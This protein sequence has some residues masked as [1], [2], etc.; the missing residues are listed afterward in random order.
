MAKV[1]NSDITKTGPLTFR[2]LYKLNNPGAPEPDDETINEMARQF[3]KSQTTITSPKKHWEETQNR[4][5]SQHRDSGIWA[6]ELNKLGYGDSKFDARL[7]PSDVNLEDLQENR[8][9]SQSTGEKLLNGVL[10]GAITSGTTFVNTLAGMPFGLVEAAVQGDVSKIWD[11]EI[12][13]AMSGI[14]EWSEKA[15]PNYYSKAELESPWY[16]QVFTANFLGDKLIKNF[17]FTIGAGAAGTMVLSRI[18]K[19]LPKVLTK[20]AVAAGRSEKDVA[21]IGRAANSLSTSF[22]SA[23]GEG[24]IEALN[25]TKEWS[26][27]MT[28]DI[29]Q[30]Y[31]EE[32]QAIQERYRQAVADLEEDFLNN[33]PTLVRDAEGNIYNP[34]AEERQKMMQALEQSM[35][36]DMQKAETNKNQRM[37]QVASQRAQTGNAVLAFNLP[38]L[39]MGNLLTLGK[40]YAKGYTAE[41][42]SIG[43]H[44]KFHPDDLANA[45]KTVK[46]TKRRLTWRGLRDVEKDVTKQ[47]FTSDVSLGKN[48]AKT[49]GS[50]AWEGTE[51]MLQGWAA[52]A[53]KD[54]N[55]DYY[56][57]SVDPDYTDK[58]ASM[59]KS[60]GDSFVSTFGNIDN[61]EEFAIGMLSGGIS[62][63]ILGQ[64]REMSRERKAV[65]EAVT[66]LNDAVNTFNN[67]EMIKGINRHQYL[68]D[69]KTSAAIEHRE[70]AYKDA[71][72]AQLASDVVLFGS[73]G[74]L[75]ELKAI[76]DYN[77]DNLSDAELQQ[78]SDDLSQKEVNGPENNYFAKLDLAGKRKYLKDQQ[79]KYHKVIDDYNNEYNELTS[80][81]GGMFSQEQMSELVYERLRTKN[82]SQRADEVKQQLKEQVDQAL[83]QQTSDQDYHNRRL[84]LHQNIISGMK[85]QLTKWSK[86]LAALKKQEAELSAK[87]SST[88]EHARQRKEGI[89]RDLEASY[90]NLFASDIA[91]QQF[92]EENRKSTTHKSRRQQQLEASQKRITQLEKQIEKYLKILNEYEA[93]TG[94]NQRTRLDALGR[95]WQ[96]QRANEK[97]TGNLKGRLKEEQAQIK[98]LQKLLHLDHVNIEG[99]NSALEFISKNLDTIFDVNSKKLY[100]GNVREAAM[101]TIGLGMILSSI[102]TDTVTSNKLMQGVTDIT[103]LLADAMNYN[104]RVSEFLQNPQKLE[105]KNKGIRE[106]VEAK[107]VERQANKVIDDLANTTDFNEFVR[108]LN[109]LDSKVKARVLEKLKEQQNKNALEYE[110]KS[111]K[112]NLVYDFINKANVEPNIKQIA[113]TI[114][115]EASRLL[116]EESLFNIDARV[117]SREA[118]QQ[119]DDETYVKTKTLLAQ[120]FKFQDKETSEPVQND[121]INAS[122]APTTTEKKEAEAKQ[123]SN[124]VNEIFAQ[125]DDDLAATQQLM[126][127]GTMNPNPQGVGNEAPLNL[128]GTTPE[129]DNSAIPPFEK[130][131]NPTPVATVTVPANEPNNLTSDK[132]EVDTT[133][134][135]TSPT[136]P[137]ASSNKNEAVMGMQEYDTK[138]GSANRGNRPIDEKDANGNLTKSAK[139]AAPLYNKLKE[140][141]AFDNVDNGVVKLGSKVYFGLLPA[142]DQQIEAETGTRSTTILMFVNG[143]CVGHLTNFSADSIGKQLGIEGLLREEFKK[144]LAS[145][146]NTNE[147]LIS[148]RYYSVVDELWT[149]SVFYNEQNYEPLTNASLQWVKDRINSSTTSEEDRT[150]LITIFDGQTTFRKGNVTYTYGDAVSTVYMGNPLYNGAPVILVPS[151]AY[152]RNKPNTQQD[153]KAYVPVALRRTLFKDL[154]EN[155]TTYKDILTTIN[156]LFSGELTIPE[157]NRTIGNLKKNLTYEFNT[158][159]GKQQIFISPAMSVRRDDGTYA[160]VEMTPQ[161]FA[162]RHTPYNDAHVTYL[163][164]QRKVGGQLVSSYVMPIALGNE[165][166]SEKL[167]PEFQKQVIDS[168]LNLL[169]GEAGA[170][171]NIDQNRLNDPKYVQQII[172]DELLQ[173]NARELKTVANS[174]HMVKEV[175]EDD[176]TQ[177]PPAVQPTQPTQTDQTNQTEQTTTAEQQAPVAPINPLD[178]L[179]GNN[180]DPTQQADTEGNEDNPQYSRVTEETQTGTID[181]EKEVNNIMRMLPQLDKETAFQI[182]NDFIKINDQ[183]DN[184]QGMFNRG[185]ITLSRLAESGTAYHEAF[186]LVFNMLLT[187][188]E[189]LALMNEY[190]DNYPN[191]SDVDLEEQ[192]ADDFKDYVLLKENN[193]PT[194]FFDRLGK[195]VLEAFNRILNFL[196]LKKHNPTVFQTVASNIWQGKY[197]GRQLSSTDND[198]RYSLPL[199]T[200]I[201]NAGLTRKEYNELKKVVDDINARYRRQKKPNGFAIQFSTRNGETAFFLTYNSGVVWENGEKIVVYHPEISE[202]FVKKYLADNHLG[203]QFKVVETGRGDFKLVAT[204]ELD[205]IGNET[206]RETYQR[207]SAWIRSGYTLTPEENYFMQTYNNKFN[208]EEVCG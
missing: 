47:A 151:G 206:P 128:S 193:R 199:A 33:P 70:K 148:K 16:T 4:L 161:N 21:A 14:E 188:D 176:G 10:K 141:G 88:R 142:L 180:F 64:T 138:A 36:R 139:Y 45:G 25:A 85:N 160:V 103:T 52:N 168:L 39:T 92:Q 121:T 30:Q 67:R 105:E 130:E 77:L 181:V 173:T 28:N 59:W 42:S 94:S 76:V 20:A 114:F 19:L 112:I 205:K 65:N 129:Q 35:I 12:T 113:L 137:P 5:V 150:P 149:G 158:D 195:K 175:R 171:V 83:Q 133:V 6:E 41:M 74:K 115:N 187:E 29:N 2:E 49:A 78:L 124:D 72:F 91:N 117:Y 56:H 100:A 9:L 26:K 123:A 8:A 208:T 61:W 110:S 204:H 3:M 111:K 7:M 104:N 107:R 145:N 152:D 99:Y 184:A 178:A 203:S 17:G 102:S 147:L 143:K 13:N 153:K 46:E 84:D 73:L 192:M 134:K 27:E 58:T 66:K 162:N 135:P 132:V 140:L 86:E 106:R 57:Q 182:V 159:Q 166:L 97:K 89:K 48:I 136:L 190:K 116:P 18:P 34:A 131:E 108:K 207:L 154:K 144:Q 44:I 32:V 125:N 120:A 40:V 101:S 198:I 80:L 183:G 1:V 126:R 79:K 201:A 163:K 202:E 185:I 196:H 37:A 50:A 90:E 194:S 96:E 118:N 55:T 177:Q 31:M 127:E 155:T 186:H 165:I 179:L 24:S 95:V 172:D 63:M 22:L 200:R 82:S 69:L 81:T 98:L 54:Y 197:A 60:L 122:G 146:P 43:E 93:G 119:L 68:E 62:N 157:L 53:S 169:T 164:I 156:S 23:A 174:F 51:E 11:N 109:T 38:I 87:I 15:L 170:Y 191:H 75:D 167:S 71:D 189:K